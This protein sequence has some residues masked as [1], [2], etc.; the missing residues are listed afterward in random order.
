MFFTVEKYTL[1]EIARGVPWWHNRLK[2]RHCRCYGSGH[3]CGTGSIPGPGTSACLRQGQKKK[4]R[5]MRK[6]EVKMLLAFLSRF[7]LTGGSASCCSWLLSVPFVPLWTLHDLG[8]PP[9]RLSV[10]LPSMNTAPV[11]DVLWHLLFITVTCSVA[12]ILKVLLNE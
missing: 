1:L 7:S 5:K 3:C 12:H 9:P 8:P 4:E 6:D 2:I 11:S 10:T